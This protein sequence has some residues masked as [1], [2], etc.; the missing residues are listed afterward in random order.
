MQKITSKNVKHIVFDHDGTLVDAGGSRQLYPGIEHML[1]RLDKEDV[2]LYVWTART[3]F[4]TVEFLKSLGIISRF[5][6]LCCST[7]SDPKPS[8]VGLRD[9]LGDDVEPKSVVVVGDSMADI[10][11][12]SNF[13]A[14]SIGALWV[15]NGDRKHRQVLLECGADQLATTASECEEKLIELIRQG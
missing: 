10:L 11:G 8:S 7:D 4:S 15:S 3:R 1:E 12:A 14:R 6:Q 13:G 5:E 9:M 2:K